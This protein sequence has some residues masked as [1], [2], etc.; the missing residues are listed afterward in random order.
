MA[1]KK[2]QNRVNSDRTGKAAGS[3]KSVRSGAQ[4]ASEGRKPGRP[5]RV[6]EPEPEQEGLVRAEVI[7]L[8]SFALAVL[9]FLSNFH[10]CGFAG[11]FLRGI[12]LG[13]FGLPGYVAPLVLFIGTC[14]YQANREN[15]IVL[16]K[17]VAT[18]AAFFLLCGFSQMMFGQ[19]PEAGKG[20]FEYYRL[21]AA[22]G[23]GGG[24]F[25]GLLFGGIRAFIGSIGAFLVMAV[26]M[27]ICMVC[28]TQ[29]SFV[30][31]VKRHS[32]VAY[33]HAREDMER[34]RELYAER[35][36][37]R[38]R[39]REEQR[40]RG[41]NLGSTKLSAS[42]N[43]DAEDMP[44]E[45]FEAGRDGS[46]E[47]DY[48]KSSEDGGSADLQA[49]SQ[50]ADEASEEAPAPGTSR[51]RRLSPE[52]AME[53]DLSDIFTGSIT[54]PEDDYDLEAAAKRLTESGFGQFEQ[55]GEV[56]T[57]GARRLD[58]ESAVN[59][60]HDQT[61]LSGH[62]QE[63]EQIQDEAPWDEPAKAE[64]EE[65]TYTRPQDP[66]WQEAAPEEYLPE[67][68]VAYTV[69][70]EQNTDFAIPEGNKHVVTAGGKVIDTDT[71]ALQKK[72]ESAKKAAAAKKEA[73]TADSEA[74]VEQQIQEKYRMKVYLS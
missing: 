61:V 12:Q 26:G 17:T 14:F 53:P 64:H 3:R 20:I 45:G 50:A 19:Q 29:R 35:Q 39:L 27:I 60:A 62:Q 63:P 54:M 5:R 6:Q 15:R 22:S 9:L 68:D 18:A 13:L 36:E 7:V 42:D 2:Q 73:E 37:E 40:V 59:P 41:V 58:E 38:R 11:D 57:G 10:L 21:S 25:G 65:C 52:E 70:T 16:Q 43:E 48:G 8:G 74:T 49:G 32:D 4:G 56:F 1:A 34:R 51:G 66:A 69:K 55:A 23:M 71:E 67:P 72:L 28:I 24:L 44:Q 31:A 46:K 30:K 47:E 33:Q